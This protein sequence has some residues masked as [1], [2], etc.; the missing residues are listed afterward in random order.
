LRDDPRFQRIRA[1]ARPPDS[2][3]EHPR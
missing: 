1:E 3:F 2:K